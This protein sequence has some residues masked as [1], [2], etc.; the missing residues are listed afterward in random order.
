MHGDYYTVKSLYS[1]HLVM[2]DIFS[3]SQPNGGQTLIKK[4]AI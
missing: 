3:R 2:A 4:P 1:G